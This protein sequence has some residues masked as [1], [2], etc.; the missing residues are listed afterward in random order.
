VKNTTVKKDELLAKVREN[1]ENH[2]RLSREAAGGYRAT[3]LDALETAVVT[4]KDGKNVDGNH[5]SGLLHDQPQD[6]TKDYDRVIGMLEMH[7][8]DQVTL[9]A[10]DFGRYVQDDWEWKDQWLASNAS[11]SGRGE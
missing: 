6:H 7:T 3:L 5:I 11:Y 4:L 10:R 1:R 2:Q 9:D 8:E